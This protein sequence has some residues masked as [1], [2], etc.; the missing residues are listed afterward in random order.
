MLN[1]TYPSKISADY[2]VYFGS[3]GQP[4]TE[5]SRP[6]SNNEAARAARDNRARE[7]KKLGYKVR[8]WTLA[9]QLR[10]Y[11]SFGVACG[12]WCNVYYLEATK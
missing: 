9:N 11:W 2:S 1:A 10:Q 3:P 5:H 12:G 8:R 6:F 4:A 7:L